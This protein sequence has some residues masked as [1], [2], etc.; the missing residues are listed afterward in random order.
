MSR[1]VK[2]LAEDV[3][4]RLEAI[5][6]GRRMDPELVPTDRILRRWAASIGDGQ[7]SDEWQDNP[8]SRVPPLDD[9]T[10]TIV[11]QIILG[12]PPKTGKLVRLWYKSGQPREVIAEAIGVKRSAMFVQHTAALWY[13]RGR[14][15]GKGIDC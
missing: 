6:R 8:K 14:F 10:A 1:R 15:Q 3:I 5:G 7:P 9:E 12:S 13:L 11:D 2:P 4:R